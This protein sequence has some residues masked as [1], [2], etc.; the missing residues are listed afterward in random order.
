MDVKVSQIPS[1]QRVRISR[2]SQK[3]TCACFLLG[4]EMC[5]VPC[6]L[7]QLLKRTGLESRKERGQRGNANA[8]C[9]H[10]KATKEICLMNTGVTE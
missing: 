8:K 4:E 9:L 3:R 10:S 2:A 7:E 1:A 6:C 5:V